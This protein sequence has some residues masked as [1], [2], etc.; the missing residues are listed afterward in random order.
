M[1][2]NNIEIIIYRIAHSNDKLAFRDFYDFYFEKLFTFSFRILKSNTLAE[3]VIS[4]V[5]MKIWT[6]RNKLSEIKNIE[7]YLYV[8]VKNR[9]LDIIKKSFKEHNT[10]FSL[11]DSHLELA[12]E[13]FTPESVYFAIE[14]RKEIDQIVKNLPI[15]CRNAFSLVKED[16]LN[17][18]QAAEILNISPNTVKSQVYKAINEIKKHLEHKVSDKKLSVSTTRG[19]KFLIS[20]MLI[21]ENFNFFYTDIV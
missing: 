15:G 13:S 9:S 10:H 14:L 11:D 4:D 5:F 12:I 1:K 8:L 7:T 17:Y 16:N 3:E 6:Q 18:A 19:V 21:I 2:M 20:V